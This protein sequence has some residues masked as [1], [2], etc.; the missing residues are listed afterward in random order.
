MARAP[1]NPKLIRKM[2]GGEKPFASPKQWLPQPAVAM[3][4]APGW[5]CRTRGDRRAEKKDVAGERDMKTKSRKIDTL[6]THA[7][8]DPA[9]NFGVV[10]PPVYHASTILYPTVKSIEERQKIRFAP[11]TYT[12]G[13]HGTP[14]TSALEEAVAAVEGGFRAVA[15][16]SGAAA[17]YVAILAFVKPGDHI[18]VADHVYGPNRSFVTGFLKRFGVEAMFYDPLI[19]AGIADLM[20]ENTRVLFMESPGSLTFE[21]QDVPTL[22]AAAKARNVVTVLDNTWASP[23][24]FH[25]LALGVDVS[26]VAGTKYI[27]GHSDVM[28]GFAICNEKSFTAVRSTVAELGYSIAPDDC[29]L[30]LRGLRTASVRMK[31][32]DKQGMALANW[33]TARPEV[34][35]VLHPALPGHPGH[36]FWKRDF[37]GASGLFGVVLKPC[38]PAALEA[39]LDGMELFGMGYSWGGFE[40][41]IIPSHPETL[42]TARPWQSAGPTLRI[43]AG[44]EDIDDLIADL[45][46]GFDRLNAAR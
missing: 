19:G 12:Y 35:R 28:V 29:Y 30:A 34:E 14:T 43:H 22:V 31:Q 46:R 10:N 21:V 15:L 27:V 44:L 3:Q 2:W 24:F 8:R 1:R 6:L 16:P 9:N 4:D 37:T 20:R 36:E 7:G 45:G 41:L 33:L 25:P 39:M 26:V 18:L 17:I 40:S 13:R 5:A 11:G 42:R 23:M 32:H 38:P